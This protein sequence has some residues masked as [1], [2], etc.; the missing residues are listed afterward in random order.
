MAGR[1]GGVDARGACDLRRTGARRRRTPQ[2]ARVADV[3]GDARAEANARRCRVIESFRSSLR[4]TGTSVPTMNAT[5]ITELT[6]ENGWAPLRAH[7][8]ARAFGIN[9][10]T[11]NADERLVG[12][13][14]EEA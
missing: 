5:T 12:E 9:A 11:K 1:R 6:R 14:T 4:P 13:H 10:Y 8:G 7:L 2:P 3:P